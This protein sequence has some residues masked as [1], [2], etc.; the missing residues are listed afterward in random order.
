MA[1]PVGRPSKYTKALSDRICSQLS[2]GISLRTV[3]LAEDMPSKQTVFSWLR[4]HK[5]FLDQYAHAKT[6]SAEAMAEEILDIADDGTNDWMTRKFG[7]EEIEVP[8]NE[9]LQ[10][11]KLRVDTR[12]W[13]MSKMQPKKYGDKLDMTTNGKDIPVPIYA[14]KS[15]K[16]RV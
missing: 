1:N 8:N 14:G 11:S 6:A 2:E 10:R 13:L 12:K 5:E 4:T 9:V 7:K 16:K 15:T 3:C